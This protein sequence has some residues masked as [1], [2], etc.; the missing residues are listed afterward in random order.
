MTYFRQVSDLLYQSQLSNRNSSE[1]YIRVKNLFRRAKIREDLYKY[2]TTF[3]KYKITGEQRPD[4]VAENY[5]GSAEYDWVVL[6]SNNIINLRTEWPLSDSEMQDFLFRK[7]TESELNE[8]H[9]YE[10]TRVLNSNGKLIVPSGEIV[11]QDYEVTYLDEENNMVV[12]TNPVTA[13][14]NYQYEVDIN[15]KKRNINLIE[16]RFLQS[17]VEDMEIIM[18][19]GFSSQY[20]DDNTKKGENLTILS[21]E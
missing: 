6:L 9:H 15:D 18:S 20:V 14:T 13:I 16:P 17:I 12:T 7:Y 3:T 4:Q 10:T 11:D 8:V 2:F 1:D 5:Y 19:Y 21:F